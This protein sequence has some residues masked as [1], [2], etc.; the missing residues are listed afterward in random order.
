[1][2]RELLEG[3]VTIALGVLVAH[4]IYRIA[5]WTSKGERKEKGR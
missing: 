3:L 5:E 1:M 2:V 4:I